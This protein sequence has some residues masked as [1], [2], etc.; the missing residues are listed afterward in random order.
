M[1][2]AVGRPWYCLKRSGTDFKL[3]QPKACPEAP[4]A[5]PSGFTI[6]EE[7]R[8]SLSSLGPTGASNL[9]PKR[10]KA[11]KWRSQ[12]PT[13]DFPYDLDLISPG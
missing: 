3:R 6:G 9:S 1:G 4:G 11:F 8:M 10:I 13:L 5:S 7:R 12:T 2:E